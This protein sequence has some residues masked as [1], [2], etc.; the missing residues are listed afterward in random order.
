MASN[1]SFFAIN[2]NAIKMRP[3]ILTNCIH[4][5]C[6]SLSECK[7]LGR[8]YKLPAH[9]VDTELKQGKNIVNTAY[10]LAYYEPQCMNKMA[11][12]KRNLNPRQNEY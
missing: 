6:F 11:S 5:R 8:F 1:L 12:T 10:S 4:L 2:Q 3:I 9:L 7:L